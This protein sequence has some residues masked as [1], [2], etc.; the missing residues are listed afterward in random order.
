[1]KK[2][3]TRTLIE[4]ALLVAIAA[5][6]LIISSAV[7]FFAP[8]GLMVW[9][10]SITL[11]TFKYNLRVSILSLVVLLLVVV[12]FIGPINTVLWGSM[13]GI[14]AIVLGVCLKRMLSPFS[15]VMAMTIA[16][17]IIFILSI[18]VSTV[19][20][21][22]D[23]L[24]FNFQ[25]ME[26][27]FKRSS[28]IMRSMGVSDE[29][30]NQAMQAF[31]I[32]ILKMLL[33]GILGISSLTIAFIIYYFAGAIFR[34]LGIRVNELKPMDQ[35]YINNN[36]SFGLFFITVAAWFMT[37][38]KVNNSDIVF[39]SVFVIFTFAFIVNGLALASWFL[40]S[41]GLPGKIRIPII[42]FILLSAFSQIL[43]YLGLIDYVLDFRRINPSRRRRIPPGE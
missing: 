2:M 19:I 28:E 29:Q 18:K 30:I 32:G 3:D 37:Y 13:Y 23:I 38:L 27:S 9:P 1:M 26:D 41:R 17:F 40:K 36:L 43:F 21:G 4:A 24:E 10:V 35:W 12:G 25:V 33:P 42:A 16:I 15:T 6:I 31:N 11:L 5:V 39:N 22:V 34:R 20:T 14:P 8:L 7:P